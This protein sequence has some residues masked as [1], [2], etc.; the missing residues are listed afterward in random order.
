MKASFGQST[1]E[2]RWLR[3]D[4]DLIHSKQHDRDVSLVAFDLLEFDGEDVRTR[5]L[6]ERKAWLQKLVAR[7]RDGI[8]YNDR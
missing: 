3:N 6:L 4:A 7:L 2:L 5:G 8:E 1:L